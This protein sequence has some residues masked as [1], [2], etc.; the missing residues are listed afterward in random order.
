MHY[1]QVIF[2]EKNKESKTKRGECFNKKN[3]KDKK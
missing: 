1:I 3:R 2:E